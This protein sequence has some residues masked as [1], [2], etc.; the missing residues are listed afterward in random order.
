MEI[1]NSSGTGVDIVGLTRVFGD[2]TGLNPL[3]L[4]LSPGEF[5]SVLGP[6]GCGK[7]T[8]LRCLAGL[9]EPD[10]GRIVFGDDVVYDS[11]RKV[12]VAVRKRGLG[13]VFQDL[14]LWPH[15]DVAGNVAF[16]LK[17]AGVGKAQI[18]ERVTAMLDRV[19]L[20]MYADKPPHQLS[21]G[22]QQRVAIARA[23]V[24]HPALLLLDEP[25]S[26]LDVALR[27]KL[28]VQLRELTT[29]LRVTSVFVTHDQTEAMSMSDRVIVMNAGRIAQIDAPEALYRRP[30]DRFVAEFL[31]A[32]NDL[33]DGGA[34]RPE[35][36][37]VAERAVD[38]D[39]TAV[40]EHSVYVG[41]VFETTCRV[42]GSVRPWLV[43][44]RDGY[45]HGEIVPLNV[46]LHARI[47]D[48]VAPVGLVHS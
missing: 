33:P 38:A 26:A 24:A 25:F 6:S 18:S 5:V 30:A 32:V 40:V 37:R 47:L 42:T 34:V 15:L 8:L 48:D 17:V 44:T 19:D 46:D 22:Q 10:A 39:V 3:D 16:P 7:S 1:R 29:Q 31:G 21:G 45:S 13:M 23:L 11:A 43:R 20:G 36:V 4:T 28:R 2:G 27:S 9:E 14:A 12:D 35:A 41:G